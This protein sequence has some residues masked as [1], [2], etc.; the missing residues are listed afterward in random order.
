MTIKDAKYE[1]HY[2]L[3]AESTHTNEQYLIKFKNNPVEYTG[4]P[5]LNIDND[6]KNTDSFYIKNLDPSEYD[7]KVPMFNISEIQYMRKIL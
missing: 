3:I 7:E 1:Q 4:N 2:Q 5:N 6:K